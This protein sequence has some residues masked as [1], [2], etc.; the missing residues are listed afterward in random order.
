MKCIDMA[1]DGIHAVILVYSCRNRFTEEEHA[2]FLTLKTLFGEKIV[3]YMIIVFTG[4][5]DLKADG[6][7]FEDYLANQPEKTL[8]VFHYHHLHYYILNL[9]LNI[10]F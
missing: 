2:T 7:T 1:K 4:K 8:Q 5:D 10:K 6:Q 9:K 3:D